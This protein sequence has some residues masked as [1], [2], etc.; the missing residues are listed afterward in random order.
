MTFLPDKI[1]FILAIFGWQIALYDCVRCYQC[2]VNNQIAGEKSIPCYNPA[3]I[4]C[5]GVADAC[6]KLIFNSE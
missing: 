1:V 4:Q 5:Y 3:Q 2:S 6:Y